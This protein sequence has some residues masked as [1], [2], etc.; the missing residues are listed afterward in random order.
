MGFG[1]LVFGYFTMF[2]FSLAPAYFFADVI[3]AL[4]AIFAF[5]KL[6]E[7]NRWFVYAM[8]ASLGFLVLCGVS[9][10]SLMFNWYD[11][12]GTVD[13]VVD[14]SKEVA[15]CLLHVFM[16][17]GIRGIAGGAENPKLVKKADRNFILTMVYYIGAAVLLLFSEAL[18]EYASYAGLYLLLYWAVCVVLNLVLIYRCF[19]TLCPADEDENAPPKPSRFAFINKLNEKFDAIEES[20]RA[21]REESMQKA[22]EEAEKR[23]AEK[24]KKH[25]GKKKH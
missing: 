4:I 1:T 23:A 17:F 18:G 15:S 14:V 24:E 11:P 8:G 5:Q 22:L 16:F 7:Y 19:G 9:A 12:A 3:G 13:G 10:G 2:A 20:K 21:Y 25:R 6:A